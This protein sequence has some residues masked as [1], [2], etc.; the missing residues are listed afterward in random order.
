MIFPRIVQ[1]VYW[2]PWL[3]TAPGHAAV[4]AILENRLSESYRAGGFPVPEDDDED[5]NLL[6]VSA[7]VGRITVAGT[8]LRK[9]TALERMCG[10]VGT[11]QIEDA[12]QRAE[13]DNTVST[14]LL[15]VDSPGGTVGGVPEL[16]ELVAECRKKV[17]AFTDGQMCSAAYWLCAG[18][19][20]IVASPSAEVGSIGVYL[21]WIDQTVRYA[22]AGYKV[23]IIRNEGADLKG[24]GYPGTAL[25]PEQRE[26]LQ[27]GVN[28]IARM[29]HA[30]VQSGR[31]NSIADD[32]MRGQAFLA[33]E[34]HD[35]GLIDDVATRAILLRQ[36]TP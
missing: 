33:E 21:P 4:R 11:E 32:T 14:I 20:R 10:A 24:M 36:L 23:D 12:L 13:A 1:A 25:T 3:I 9:A 34:A 31:G 16:G 17:V 2:Q 7:G 27:A 6:S 29:F 15:D 8:I 35:R 22:L 30:A 18:A 19:D 5:G 26:H 28:E